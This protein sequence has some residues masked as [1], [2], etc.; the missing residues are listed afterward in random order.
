MLVLLAVVL[1]CVFSVVIPAKKC[2]GF[3][4][5]DNSSTYIG[6]KHDLDN[7]YVLRRLLN[8]K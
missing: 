3:M 1:T 5:T 2:S 6:T 7:R 8:S 4:L